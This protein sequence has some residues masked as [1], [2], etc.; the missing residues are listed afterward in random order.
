MDLKKCQSSPLFW[1]CCCIGWSLADAVFIF[2]FRS[3]T[4]PA[5]NVSLLL[6]SAC[7]IIPPT[8]FASQ[9]V[10]LSPLMSGCMILFSGLAV[11]S[12]GFLLLLHPQY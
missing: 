11:A 10:L 7:L 4:E 9:A 8:L 3:V 12:Y 2:V 6:I 1:L 5:S